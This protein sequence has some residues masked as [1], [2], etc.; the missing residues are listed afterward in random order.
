MRKWPI[1]GGMSILQDKLIFV[2]K[3]WVF[4]WGE[5]KTYYD[6]LSKWQVYSYVNLGLHG[7]GDTPWQV[8]DI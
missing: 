2:T 1:T 7:D 8:G 5:W 6:N 4:F 3:I